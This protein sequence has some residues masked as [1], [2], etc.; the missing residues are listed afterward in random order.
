MYAK[1]FTQIYDGTLCTK[2][3]WEALVTFQQML[4]LADLDGNVDM[5]AAAIS[6]RTTIPLE[7]I[8]RGLA[9]L[10]KPDPDSRTPT[11]E[12]RRIVPLAEGRTWGWR[13]V[14][15]AHYRELKR[16]EDRRE[17]HRQYWHKR[18]ASHS[19]ASTDST[20]STETQHAQQNQP[21]QKQKQKQDTEAEAIHGGKPPC[22]PPAPAALSGKPARKRASKPDT[23]SVW[24]AYSQ[25]YAEKYGVQPV[26]NA[27]VNG[28]L[29]QL[30]SRLGAD[31]APGVARSYIA[32]RNGLY[33]ASK[34]CVDLLLRDC[35]KLRTEWVTGNVGHQRDAREEDRMSATSAMAQR[36]TATLEAKGVK[37]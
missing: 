28:Q 26:R 10:I 25:A 12:G 5:T 18:K 11:E 6:R 20:H 15:Y 14:N 2:G 32:S 17:Y 30:V 8:E 7:I 36:I 27:K 22:D 35:E 9:E 13:I 33:V 16:E 31:E 34:H 4:V 3:P 29:S 1:V 21:K 24:D 23:G 19:T 37:L